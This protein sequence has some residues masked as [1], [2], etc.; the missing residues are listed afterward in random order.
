MGKIKYILII[1]I[2]IPFLL[3]SQ[4]QG[5][6]QPEFTNFSSVNNQELV[7]ENTGDLNY[8]IPLLNI[9]GQNGFGYTINLSYNSNFGPDDEASW[10]G[11][12]WGLNMG[13]I[14]RG[15][16]GFPDDFNDAV[17]VYYNKKPS[18]ISINLG[19]NVNPELMSIEPDLSANLN[20]H[21][22]N[23]NGFAVS[24]GAGISAFKGIANLNFGV[25]RTGRL[26]GG[27]NFDLSPSNILNLLEDYNVTSEEIKSVQNNSIFRSVGQISPLTQ[28][29]ITTSDR[30]FNS[31]PINPPSYSTSIITGKFSTR[32]D[33]FQKVGGNVN[34]NGSYVQVNYDEFEIKKAY[35]YF[36]SDDA[37]KKNLA[38]SYKDGKPSIKMD[39][40]LDRSNPFT[41]RD[42]FLSVPKSNPDEFIVQ[43]E[44]LSGGFRA[45]FDEPVNFAP[46]YQNNKNLQVAIG[47]GVNY[48]PM[49]IDMLWGFGLNAA[50]DVF[51]GNSILPL[52]KKFEKNS[53]RFIFHNDKAIHQSYNPSLNRPI[54]DG[55]DFSVSSLGLNSMPN[56]QVSNYIEYRTIGEVL[57][58]P[59]GNFN[60]KLNFSSFSRRFSDLIAE[61][62]ITNTDGNVYIFG[63]PVF[64]MNERN[65]S[66]ILPESNL[67]KVENNKFYPYKLDENNL[68]TKFGTTVSHPYANSYLMTE[69]RS[70]NYFDLTNNGPT[71]DDV[72][73]YVSFNYMRTAG[74]SRINDL[75]I[76]Y[77]DKWFEWRMPYEGYYYSKGEI[78]NKEDDMVSYSS[79][80]K[81]LLYPHSIKTKTHVAIFI[82]NMSNIEYAED[83]EYMKYFK[84]RDDFT[85]VLDGNEIGN[86][87]SEKFGES[88][89]LYNLLKGSGIERKDNWPFN[90]SDEKQL[91]RF[92]NGNYRNIPSN[93]SRKL[94][95]ILLFKLDE[96]NEAEWEMAEKI[97]DDNNKQVYFVKDL[98]KVINL[99]ADYELRKGTVN[100]ALDNG[101]KTGKLS[102]KKLWTDNN[103]TFENQISPYEFQYEYPDNSVLDYPSEFNYLEDFGNGKIENPDY[104]EYQSNSWNNYQLGDDSNI[105]SIDNKF[106]GSTKS[107]NLVP[108]VNNIN[109]IEFDPAPWRLKRVVLPSQG[110]IHLQYDEKDYSNV[111][112]RD[113]MGMFK[114]ISHSTS[115]SDKEYIIDL[116]D[117]YENINPV[118]LSNIQSKISNE[119]TN[120]SGGKN[121]KMYGKLLLNYDNSSTPGINDCNS[122]YIEGFVNVKEVRL[123]GNNIIIVTDDDYF[124]ENCIYKYKNTKNGIGCNSYLNN[125]FLTAGIDAFLNVV[126]AVTTINW[127]SIGTNVCGTINEDLSY[128]RLPLVNINKSQGGAR[129]KRVLYYDKFN[130][131][132]NTNNDISLY[133]TEYIYENENGFSSG[134]ASNEPELIGNENALINII[135]LRENRNFID[136][137]LS[138]EQEDQN[139]GPINKFLLP[140]P[141]INYARVV[142]KRI[143]LG[144]KDETGYSKSHDGFTIKEYFTYKDNPFDKDYNLYLNSGEKLKSANFTNI[145]KYEPYVPLIPNP[146]F[147]LDYAS[148]TASQG[149]LFINNKVNGL[150]KSERLYSGNYFN[151]DTWSLKYSKEYEY[152]E[153][154]SCLPIFK[155]FNYTSNSNTYQN[156]LKLEGGLPG[157]EI[158]SVLEG[159]SII[160]RSNIIQGN[161]DLDMGLI[162][163]PIVPFG[164]IPIIYPFPS[165]SAKV[166]SNYRELNTMVNATYVDFSPTLTSIKE[167]RDGV[168][169]ISNN[170]IF[171]SKTGNPILTRTSDEFDKAFTENNDG[172]IYNYNFPASYFYPSFNS[173]ESVN[174]ESFKWDI[175][176][177]DGL[178]DYQ[179]NSIGSPP[180]PSFKFLYLTTKSTKNVD[181][182]YNVGDRVRVDIEFVTE[183][184]SPDINTPTNK[185]SFIRNDISGIIMSVTGNDILVVIDV[186]N[187]GPAAYLGKIN[188]RIENSIRN[189][190]L[191]EIADQI[192][193]YSSDSYTSICNHDI[194][195]HFEADYTNFTN[196]S[197]Q[198]YSEIINEN[199]ELKNH[200][201]GVIANK[202]NNV[203]FAESYVNL[204]TFNLE[205]KDAITGFEAINDTAKIR[206]SFSIIDTLDLQSPKDSVR[207]NFITNKMNTLKGNDSI[208]THPLIKDLN[209][210]LDELWSNELT[211][212][213]NDYSWF[214]KCLSDDTTGSNISN[215]FI[216]NLDSLQS[217]NF[218]TNSLL[219]NII[220]NKYVI[221]DQ[222]TSLNI[223]KEGSEIILFDSTKYK[224]VSFRDLDTNEIIGINRKS[225]MGEVSFRFINDTIIDYFDLGH[226][227]YIKPSIFE[228]DSLQSFRIDCRDTLLLTN[229][230][231]S[232]NWDTTFI[233]LPGS[234]AISDTLFFSDND[235]LF[236]F[237][238]TYNNF[239]NYFGY[240]DVNA[241]GILRYNTIGT[242][243]GYKDTTSTDLFKIYELDTNL[244][245]NVMVQ[246][247][248]ID[249]T[250]P[251][252]PFDIDTN[253]GASLSLSADISAETDVNS[254]YHI[255]F[256]EVDY[257]FLKANNVLNASSKTFDKA[258]TEL[259]YFHS[260]PQTL[261]HA[262][263]VNYNKGE[264]R[265][266]E[267]RLYNASKTY[268]S[269]YFDEFVT[270]NHL[271]PSKNSIKWQQISL[272]KIDQNN[273]LVELT[274]L[275]DNKSTQFFNSRGQTIAVFNNSDL[276]SVY[277]T[278]FETPNPSI[279]DRISYTVS[280]NG[281]NSLILD[282][283]ATPPLDDF[284]IPN[285]SINQEAGAID[286][287]LTQNLKSKGIHL[288]VWVKIEEI[289]DQRYSNPLILGYDFSGAGFIPATLTKITQTGD[290]SLFESKILST[291]LN[292]TSDN[293]IL[294]FGFDDAANTSEKVYIDDLLIKPIGA[295]SNCYVFNDNNQ[296]IDAILDNSHMSSRFQY[297]SKGDLVRKIKETYEGVKTI[298]D[299][300]Y[301]TPKV[302]RTSTS[303]GLYNG[304]SNIYENPYPNV[305][306]KY[307]DFI[308][309]NE[310]SKPLE[311]NSKF[312]I[313]DINMSSD[314]TNVK[315]FKFLF[316]NPIDSINIK[317]KYNDIEVEKP[318]I[319]DFPVD[320]INIPSSNKIQMNSLDNQINKDLKDTIGTQNN[321]IRFMKQEKK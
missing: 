240:F 125:N 41:T 181:E 117:Y 64:S 134:V 17:V 283:S 126:S 127:G 53:K 285:G 185:S 77:F 111:Q 172:G 112:N 2:Q 287:P 86:Y 317:D 261:F 98:V 221:F 52:V 18:N 320:S 187:F 308:K 294:S 210:L 114:L 213:K 63:E 214:T 318:Q 311:S 128:F 89:K 291:E 45:H 76:G 115:G 146:F 14:T 3:F 226:I 149:Y 158:E 55:N 315:F 101:N 195:N 116:S 103:N 95:R 23:Q 50:G 264:Y 97:G 295:I 139:Y 180:F 234:N 119:F 293:I 73:E 154:G 169:N 199:I 178:Y 186:Q 164:F 57:K 200:F 208:S 198:T 144:A 142:S 321:I 227:K 4:I 183:Q 136:A 145:D 301:N 122:E 309:Y 255:K 316:D 206:Y 15:K 232:D 263:Y 182:Y 108:S 269:G 276:E 177:W 219:K 13:S 271:N 120:N 290:W 93:P 62:K 319:P 168:V 197:G 36:Y 22:N 109:P 140:S 155:G 105:G 113:I 32:L 288:K 7:N 258:T 129:V 215:Y 11:W 237:M 35:G 40:S 303:S 29:G 265:Y 143:G 302:E 262:N 202:W 242:E 306:I 79:G 170:L 188:L 171:D 31:M 289:A 297:N 209:S 44:G 260:R 94:E 277:F 49:T 150:A 133:G 175:K 5:P 241:L 16:N 28:L 273:H 275:N 121:R 196:K 173:K 216:D 159:K 248:I 131:L 38:K 106:L 223:V 193:I 207:V 230:Y 166:N 212:Y 229:E 313:I 132:D 25:D 194:P 184:V 211:N 90:S 138:N 300:Q 259:N 104:S 87:Y 135:E 274:D 156:P 236:K 245:E 102:L 78:S 286:F 161:Y 61:F 81:E 83:R 165:F 85:I 51:G 231:I 27:Y 58:S 46:S 296:N 34:I 220:D 238:V 279:G 80:Q 137:F 100:S 282:E 67:N 56:D 10:V 167:T 88:N 191:N 153:P 162:I 43:A 280:H 47:G 312:D 8:S 218:E 304:P 152:S 256:K 253:Q 19:V 92:S 252:E 201:N 59:K 151:E 30:R 110:E 310:N 107:N 72:G 222:D 174:T 1:L 6:T 99:E 69:I 314:S 224:Y 74:R 130:K 204:D 189:N 305:R 278:S 124:S 249:P 307:T 70:S 267:K 75:G 39:Y 42:Y 179:P 60:K 176:K 91:N 246:S 228:T 148:I 247:F 270:F 157:I 123:D 118:L 54:V 281:S 244:Y 71:Q 12:G 205:I 250:K 298:A 147:V 239:T 203:D 243:Y 268:V 33:A 233:I 160:E 96:E 84:I 284:I 254:Y 292:T 141:T 68:D 163:L 20:L 66:F 9:P 251:I 299:A 235:S 24:Y 37:E 48:K 266:D 190:R 192:S 225:Y 26:S 82:T 21:Y 257:P 272:S 217:L 65:L